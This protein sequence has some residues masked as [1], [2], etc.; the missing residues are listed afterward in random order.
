MSQ[1]EDSTESD[2]E[3][4]DGELR[5]SLVPETIEVSIEKNKSSVLRRVDTQGNMISTADFSKAM[6][7][8]YN[9]SR[10]E[11]RE[12]DLVQSGI[13]S[14]FLRGSQLDVNH[15]GSLHGSAENK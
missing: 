3:D 9:G 14:V 10:F 12:S 6:T 2:F 13:K 11:L 7:S 1:E 15:A 5:S 4:I 8:G